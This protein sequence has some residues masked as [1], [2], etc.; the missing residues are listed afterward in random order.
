MNEG[1]SLDTQTQAI[2]L[3]AKEMN[4]KLVEV[5]ADSTS[6]A[7]PYAKRSCLKDAINKAESLGCPII[8]ASPD[9]LS[10]NLDVLRHLD[11][12]KTHV[13]VVGRGRLT[14]SVLEHE[15]AEAAHG[16]Q[17]RSEAGAS[18]WTSSARKKR[19]RGSTPAS[20][21]GGLVGSK[22]NKARSDQ[23]VVDIQ[24]V[25]ETRPET[26]Q[27]T[28]PE[29]ALLL[30]ALGVTNK[31]GRDNNGSVLW[32]TETLRRKLGRARKAID[33]TLRT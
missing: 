25:L 23:N 32:T 33:A 28:C 13:W 15:L 1:D 9:R 8:V 6:G 2:E 17:Q 4:R 12:R 18:S 30:N 21:D 11:L 29:L 19:T 16:L 3:Y 26:G 10:R 20:R 7:L 31:N 27:M 14:R 5:H 24:R 22:G